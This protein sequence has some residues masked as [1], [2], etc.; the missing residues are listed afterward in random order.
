MRE[1]SKLLTGGR[2]DENKRTDK[3]KIERRKEELLPTCSKKSQNDTL[4]RFDHHTL[5]YLPPV[6]CVSHKTITS[7]RN[8]LDFFFSRITK[9]GEKGNLV[10]DEIFVNFYYGDVIR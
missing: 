7:R 9:I 3:K 5:Q 8:F 2:Q 4:K 6:E 10:F 1:S